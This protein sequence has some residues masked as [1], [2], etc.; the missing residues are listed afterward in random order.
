[1]NQVNLMGNVTKDIELQEAATGTKY[2]QFR[3]AVHTR[4]EKANA[5]FID[6]VAFNKQA[7]I[8]SQ[9]VKK[10]SRICIEGHL[11]DSQ[12]IDYE[13]NK[14]NTLK[15]ILDHFEFADTKKEVADQEEIAASKE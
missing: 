14:R 4:S 5:N 15:V 3:I 2:V 11:T 6:I 12:Y 8:L 9:Y 7:E 1:M 10:G 13:G